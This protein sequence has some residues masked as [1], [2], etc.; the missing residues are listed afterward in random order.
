MPKDSSI[1]NRP[2]LTLNFSAKEKLVQK[3]EQKIKPKA[4][5][6]EPEKQNSKPVV[7]T[8]P[9]AEQKVAQLKPKAKADKNSKSVAEAQ[10]KPKSK[11][12]KADNDAATKPVSESDKKN[13][14]EADKKP[15]ETKPKKPKTKKQL[16]AIKNNKLLHYLR[17]TY[18]ECF[19][20]PPSPLAIGIHRQLQESE[21]VK[22]NSVMTRTNIYQTLKT[23][24]ARKDYGA[25]IVLNAP[26]LNLD[27]TSDSVVTQQHVD[28]Q[29][30]IDQERLEQEQIQ[31]EKREA[32]KLQKAQQQQKQQE[33]KELTDT[34]PQELPDQQPEET[35]A[36]EP[37][38]LPEDQ[39]NKDNNQKKE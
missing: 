35:P 34:Q 14:E 25:T 11:A 12:D 30:K 18:P 13:K 1:K 20:T 9:A 28:N 10:L 4:E 36:S 31:Q 24:T 17:T 33:K 32:K 23:Y 6:A 15:K 26:R 39:T 8:E 19:T 27:G 16:F 2:I 21:G 5:K 7:S 29:Q 37:Q 22:E 3:L 38:E